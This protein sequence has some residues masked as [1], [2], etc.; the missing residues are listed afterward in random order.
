[1]NANYQPS[2]MVLIVELR[3]MLNAVEMKEK[4]DPSVLF[5]KIV[6]IKKSFALNGQTVEEED[7]IA[8]VMEKSP[9]YYSSIL[10]TETRVKVNLLEIQHL[11]EAMDVEY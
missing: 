1:M 10:A 11:E 8:T 5:K 3:I 4:D 7:L 9:S 6:C 2:D